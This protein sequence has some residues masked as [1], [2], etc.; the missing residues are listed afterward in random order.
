[1]QPGQKRTDLDSPNKDKPSNLVTNKD[2]SVPASSEEIDKYFRLFSPQK[3]LSA[4]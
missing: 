4:I 3:Y 2:K 1:M